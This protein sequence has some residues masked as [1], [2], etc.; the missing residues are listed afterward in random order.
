ME[1]W[2]LRLLV[3]LEQHF[4][5]ATDG[6]IYAPGP[7]KYEFWQPFL[8]AF[9]EITV[10][11]RVKETGAVMPI[12]QRAD[13]PSVTF[14]RLS[15]YVGPWEYLRNL[16]RLR[17]AVRRAVADADAYILRVPGA[18]G[19]LAIHEVRHLGRVYAVEVVGD[20]WDALSTGSLRT[21]L[22]PMYRRLWTRNLRRHC[23]EAVAVHYVTRHTHQKRYPAGAKAY[24]CA[25][26]DVFLAG[27][28]ADARMIERRKERIREVGTKSGRPA[29][30]GFVGSMGVY[31]K[32]AD[33]LLKAIAICL[34]EGVRL[35]AHL[36]GDGRVRPQFEV[37]SA[38]LGIS[39]QIH[40]H[41][42]LPAGKA[43]FDFLDSIDLF[44]MPSRVEG[45]PRAMVEAMA[46]GCPC[47]GSAVGGIPELLPPEAL[48]PP[49]D[50]RELARTIRRFVSSH[51]FMSYMVER[52]SHVAQAFRPE[53][54]QEECRCF[55]SE[56][57]SRSVAANSGTLVHA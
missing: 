19:D 34:G 3:G 21:P 44:V 20:P 55:L 52:N 18:I 41:G 13:G 25:F 23:R 26:S 31:Y 14:C 27:N 42:Q 39:K 36:I 48:V 28:L 38:K 24:S 9:E 15:D 30:L 53:L 56:V 16:G 8:E 1:A 45:L 43:V 51:D 4:L 11:A 33:V 29:Q 12:E 5:A 35:E 54:L 10:L 37:L 32:G 40:F 50:E 17:S 7:E 22:R 57:R 6:C 2:K 46:R 49:S 47:I